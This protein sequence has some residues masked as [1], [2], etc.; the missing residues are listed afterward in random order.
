MRITIPLATKESAF[1]VCRA[2]AVPMPQP[3]ND[4][5]I[6]W[7]LEAPHLAISE[8]NDDTAL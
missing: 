3:E 2:S 5:A 6:E 1:T 4:M 8:N 7:E